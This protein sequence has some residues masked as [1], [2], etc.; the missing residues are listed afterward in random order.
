[1]VRQMAR[2]MPG[3]RFQ[4]GPFAIDK[5]QYQQPAEDQVVA[6]AKAGP[7]Y[8]QALRHTRGQ[9][10]QGHGPGPLGDTRSDG[11]S[12]SGISGSAWTVKDF[13]V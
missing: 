5:V 1:M 8:P 3:K 13:H 2:A 4:I 9:T 12:R 6:A 11:H 7:E 10:G